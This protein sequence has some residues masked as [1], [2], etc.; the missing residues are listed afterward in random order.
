MTC[1]ALIG[2]GVSQGFAQE[3]G[4]ARIT[5]RVRDRLAPDDV[6]LLDDVSHLAAPDGFDGD[7]QANFEALAG[8]ID[9]IADA[10][11][12]LDLLSAAQSKRFMGFRDAA[13]ELHRIYISIVGMVF[14]E[15]DEYCVE[16]AAGAPGWEGMNAL[17]RDFR[18][19]SEDQG[20]A[21]YTLNYDSL[22]QSALLHEDVAYYDGFRDVNGRINSPLDS[23]GNPL[24]MYQLHGSLSW[25]D[26]E[27][28]G[29][30]KVGHEDAREFWLPT[31][32][33]GE[34]EDGSPVVVLSDIKGRVVQRYPFDLFYQEFMS[35]LK[36]AQAVAVA[37][38]GFGDVPVN[39][40][41]A[42][43]LA[44]GTDRAIS[45]FSPHAEENVEAWTAALQTIHDTVTADQLI[46]VNA[47][48]PTDDVFAN[49]PI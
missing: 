3:L 4:L 25:V 39:A 34:N 13:R 23:W 30:T 18:D 9:R 2:N 10:L 31:W 19:L 36:G 8:P 26:F 14:E 42:D 47:V 38:Y 16:E 7:A 32:A 6:D 48:L 21:I 28:F 37:G 1:V 45:V 27:D 44:Q 22:L 43:Y 35:D 17:A 5:T 46:P 11:G 24:T 20:L 29:V 49:W 12:L 40:R 33:E 15:I 41:L